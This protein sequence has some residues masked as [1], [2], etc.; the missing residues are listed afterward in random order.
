MPWTALDYGYFETDDRHMDQDRNAPTVQ[1]SDAQTGF[2]PT[3]GN[4]SNRW[5]WLHDIHHGRGDDERKNERRLDGIRRDIDVIADRLGATDHQRDRAEWL[6]EQIDIEDE[7]L[8]MGPIEEAVIGVLSIVIDEDR[9]RYGRT[10][11][12]AVTSV[13]RDDSFETMLDAFE[14]ERTKVHDVRRRLRETEVYESPN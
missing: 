6:L 2:D 14:V 8:P 7:L 4:D 3:D 12:D 10:N 9:T 13:T 1:L 11:D 5:S